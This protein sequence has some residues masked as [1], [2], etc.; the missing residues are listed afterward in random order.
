MSV[1]PGRGTIVAADLLPI[2]PIPGVKVIRGDF[3]LG[4]TTQ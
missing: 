3:L 4:P 1:Q 2:V